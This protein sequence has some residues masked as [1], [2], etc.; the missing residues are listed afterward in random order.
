MKSIALLHIS[1]PF[2]D[3]QLLAWQHTEGYS[4]TTPPACKH[5]EL[6]RGRYPNHL[7]LSALSQGVY[8]CPC[9]CR[10]KITDN[11]QAKSRYL[12]ISYDY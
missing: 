5:C 10:V 1:I 12:S 4:H 7:V 3:P 2:T 11:K 8:D 6:Q 9:N